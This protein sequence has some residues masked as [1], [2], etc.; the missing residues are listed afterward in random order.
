MGPRITPRESASAVEQVRARLLTALHL[1]QHKPGD[2]APSIRRMATLTGL[3]RKTV[4]RAYRQLA[5]EGLLGVKW[6]SGTFFSEARPAAAAHNPLAGAL[7]E[8][9]ERC[10]VEAD[11]LGVA[12][13]VF[14]RF[15]GLIIGGRLRG[16]EVAVAECN[17]EQTGLIERELRS[18]LGVATRELLISDAVAHHPSSFSGVRA[19]V[20]TDCHRREVTEMFAP[21]GIPVYRVALAPGFTHSLIR[22]ARQGP[23]LMVVC[24]P[25]Y[26][27]IFLRMLRQLQ[28]PREVLGRFEIVGRE[29]FAA[30]GR[31]GRGT[32]SIYVSPLVGEIDAA[33]LRG[34]RRIRPQRYLATT[35][36]EALKVHLALELAMREECR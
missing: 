32:G 18:A 23:V 19:V 31:T 26:G 13:D 34:L 24:D 5:G 9:V 6:G 4:H 17:R 30:R 8:A 16:T 12:S 14:L 20:T 25:S 29:E 27:K 7:L 1:G 33:A 3:N 21:L 35:S 36:V 22:C 11:H 15:L 28:V 2:R 10:R